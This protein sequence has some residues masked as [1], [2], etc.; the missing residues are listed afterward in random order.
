MSVHEVEVWRLL[1]GLATA[2][3]AV[4]ALVPLLRQPAIRY[5]LVDQPT[6]RKRHLGSVPLV[7]GLAIF[8]A[9]ALSLVAMDH[10]ELWKGPIFWIWFLVLFVG[11]CDDVGDLPVWLRVLIQVSAIVLLCHFSGIRL[12]HLGRLTGDEPITLGVYALPLTILGLIGVKNGVNLLDGLDGLAGTQVL[13]VLTWFIFLSLENQAEAIP[14]MCIPLL[15]AV[16]GFLLFNLRFSARPA[17]IFLGDHGSVFLGFTLGWVAVVGSQ[18]SS[19]AFSPIEAVWVLGI[20]VMDTIRV[21]LS[22]MI[23]GESPFKPGRDHVH[24]LLLDS[25]WSVNAVVLLLMVASLMVGGV[26]WLGR[27]LHWPEVVLL[28]LFLLLSAGYFL[29]L[30][31]LSRRRDSQSL[32]TRNEHG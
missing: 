31:H 25:G 18:V 28:C 4:I 14:L 29:G 6:E 27:M 17:R 19:P 26:T 12:E 24:H 7:G 2:F 1:L 22:R 21:M 30:Q 23:R 13:V 16:L 9:Y 15:G 3:M 20:P 8:I 32:R 10:L 5:G 11:L